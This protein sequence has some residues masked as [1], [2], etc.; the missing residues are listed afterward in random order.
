LGLGRSAHAATFLTL[1]FE[2]ASLEVP[3]N[4]FVKKKKKITLQK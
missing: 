2:G 4:Q 3:P 1:S